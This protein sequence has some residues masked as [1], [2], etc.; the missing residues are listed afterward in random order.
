MYGCMA[1]GSAA[2]L[3]RGS[4]ESD[5]EP[6]TALLVAFIAAIFMCCMLCGVAFTVLLREHNAHTLVAEERDAKLGQMKAIGAPIGP[7]LGAV[8][9]VFSGLFDG[10][11]KTPEFCG[12][13][14]RRRGDGGRAVERLLPFV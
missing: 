3:A 10:V 5:Q 9:R 12:L 14:G 4:A 7:Q 2:A 1:G 8:K 13:P 6:W 11:A